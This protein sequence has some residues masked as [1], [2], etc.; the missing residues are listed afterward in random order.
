MS[1]EHR[2]ERNRKRRAKRREKRS[3]KAA[4]EIENQQSVINLISEDRVKIPES[5]LAVLTKGDGFVPTPRFNRN[6]F[7]LDAQ[8]CQNRLGKL[9]KRKMTESNELEIGSTPNCSV[10]IEVEK[11]LKIPKSLIT[12]KVVK[13]Q[14]KTKN[15]AV[16]YIR[17]EIVEFGNR[18]NFSS[19]KM[20]IS[21]FER[22]GLS[23][24][25]EA[26]EKGDICILKA[27]KGSAIIIMT[28]EEVCDSIR[29]KV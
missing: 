8:N 21:K 26:V 15:A 14:N 12:S 25:K 10:S 11:D 28:P 6:E 24:L 2:R 16:E 23:W 3:R 13:A 27:D 7:R 17:E 18:T 1:E 4:K 19:P 22:E 9:T 5:S 29:S 20:N